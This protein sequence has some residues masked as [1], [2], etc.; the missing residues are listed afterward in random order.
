M[1]LTFV[2]IR[3]DGI[4]DLTM[5]YSYEISNG[6]EDISVIPNLLMEN[7]R[8]SKLHP[9]GIFTI[10][11]DDA[12]LINSLPNHW[13]FLVS[14]ENK[15][16]SVRQTQSIGYLLGSIRKHVEIEIFENLTHNDIVLSVDQGLLIDHLY[17]F[18]NSSSQRDFL[19]LDKTKVYAKAAYI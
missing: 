11:K 3:I 19:F 13:L 15:H 16:G 10:I 18:S 6:I 8:F 14:A 17:S 5:H 2:I 7:E 9:S 1:N 12:D 4:F